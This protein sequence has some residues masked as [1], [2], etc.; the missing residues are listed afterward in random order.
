[1]LHFFITF[2]CPLNTFT[3]AVCAAFCSDGPIKQMYNF[4]S[5]NY[6]SD[7]YPPKA[8][9]SSE[10]E[11]TRSRILERKEEGRQKARAC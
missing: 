11:E 8:I 3:S 10:R 7:F 5:E 1:M 2:F 9:N 4:L 6:A